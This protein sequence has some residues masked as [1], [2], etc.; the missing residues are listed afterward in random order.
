MKPGSAGSLG[1]R[2]TAEEAL[3]G[4]SLAG[5]T[6]I[7]TGAS[8]GIGVETARVLAKAGAKVILA[9]RALPAG[10]EVAFRI[11]Q[12]TGATVEVK[13]LDL[14][15]LLSVRAFATAFS[16]SGQSLE[17]L[18]NNA[19]V[20]A[21]PL[22]VT[23]QHVELQLGTNHVGPFYL[24][25]LLRPAL[26]RGAPSRI[27]TVSSSLHRRGRGE[28]LLATIDD[29]RTHSRRKYVP[30]DAYGDSKLA[31]V[32]F[33]RELAKVLPKGVLAFTLHPGVIPTPLSRSLGLRG[34]IFRIAGR[35]FM[36]SVA[37]GA[38]TSIYAATA[39]ELA[40]RSGA[41]LEDCQIKEPS[42]DAQDDA[43]AKKL[44]DA[45]EKLIASVV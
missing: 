5:K 3:R 32:L 18:V 4:A 22:G 6:A 7:V 26:A 21:T 44:W 10:E 36:K 30:F 24:T 20:M 23:K 45:T 29:D 14:T 11:R 19:G 33:T 39:P 9:V 15:D 2:T 17:L 12:E 43:L 16:E 35:P 37:Q 1:S 41:Y 40:D 31:N 13:H 34:A 8:S 42:R 28:R 27:V 25:N 38:A